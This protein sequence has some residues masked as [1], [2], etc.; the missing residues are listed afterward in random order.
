MNTRTLLTSVAFIVI[1][2][3]FGLVLM[4][5]FMGSDLSDIL[6]PRFFGTT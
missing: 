1:I 5:V 2:L 4:R 3:V 6:I